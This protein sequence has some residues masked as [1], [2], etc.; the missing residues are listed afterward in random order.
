M[1]LWAHEERG[2]ESDPSLRHPGPVARAGR[3]SAG[4]LGRSEDRRFVAGLGGSA[5]GLDCRSARFDSHEPEPLDSPGKCPR[6]RGSKAFAP[7]RTTF[8][9]D[10]RGVPSFTEGFGEGAAG[11][12]IEP[13]AM[14]W[15]HLGNLLEKALRDKLEGP[16][17]AVLD[18][19]VGLSLETGGLQ[20]PPGPR[21]GGPTVPADAKKNF[22]AW[23][24]VKPWFFRTRPVSPCIRDWAGVGPN[25]GSGCELP[26]PVAITPD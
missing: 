8:P 6:C 25:A 24:G 26:P 16:P 14:G 7:S 18:A 20:L 17:S 21:R 10:P 3:A 15:S 13:S 22:A 2:I 19:P 12:G 9:A 11:T 4:G 1:V 5:T 23:V